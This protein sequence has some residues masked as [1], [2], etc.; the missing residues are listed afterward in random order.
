MST[1][2]TV[3][4]IFFPCH[5]EIP[6]KLLRMYCNVALIL[7]RLVSTKWSKTRLK[8]GPHLSRKV[9]LFASMKAL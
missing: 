5:I 4:S 2:K 6:P 9:I 7:Q 8:S 1:G 3:N